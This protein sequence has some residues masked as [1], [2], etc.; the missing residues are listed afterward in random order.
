MTKPLRR[1]V[2]EQEAGIYPGSTVRIALISG[3]L[4]L[5]MTTTASPSTGTL[6]TSSAHG[7]V[8]GARI[9]LAP[10]AAIVG[11]YVPGGTNEITD[12]F[13][14]VLSTTTLK[15]ATTLA[16]ANA[17]AQLTLTSAGQGVLLNQQLLV[18][19]DPNSVIISRELPSGN[20]YTE[21]ASTTIGNAVITGNEAWQT[22]QPANIAATGGPLIYRH[23]ALFL[24]SSSSIGDT[25]GDLLDLRT[26]TGNITI[27]S[28]DIKSL[29][30]RFINQ[31]GW[32]L[33]IKLKI[34]TGENTMTQKIAD[35]IFK[36]KRFRV[37]RYR[38]EKLFNFEYVLD[39]M[40]DD[41]MVA[42][43]TILG[44]SFVWLGTAY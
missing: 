2:Q 38:C 41:L 21:R 24:N 32:W 27:A 34:T 5:N 23:V 22:S 33:M 37:Q 9:R 43:V 11:D 16:N 19:D 20:G 31:R 8:T 25:S 17:G 42:S 12:Y 13:A 26:E 15:L 4:A 7:L 14:I 10:A 40:S 6:T 35:E 3:D 36:L 39:V 29:V 30:E 1:L 44:V 28:G 18:A